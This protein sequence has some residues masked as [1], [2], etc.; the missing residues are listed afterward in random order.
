MYNWVHD[1]PPGQ[2]ARD[3]FENAIEHFNLNNKNLNPRVLEVGTY[4]GISL[5][6]IIS[7]IP[8]SIGFGIDR[9]EDYNEDNINILKSIK[10]NQVENSFY[11]NIQITGLQERITGI[12]G[13]SVNVLLELLKKEEIFD[14]IYVDGSHKCLDVHLDLFLSW[15]L[16]RKTGILAIDDYMYNYDKVKEQP[17]EYPFEGVNDF[18][19]KHEN[20]Y[21]ILSKDY[22]IFLEKK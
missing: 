4:A 10:S 2:K 20:E 13:D 6:N 11:H 15:R 17:F 19:K 1:L 14:F 9:W 8:N 7:R 22:R 16:L 21:I 5:I 12:K 18:L 3:K